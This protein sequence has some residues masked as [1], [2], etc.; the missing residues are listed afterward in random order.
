[1]VVHALSI[2]GI[3]KRSCKDELSIAL[4]LYTGLAACAGCRPQL[5]WDIRD[6]SEQSDCP[7]RSSPSSVTLHCKAAPSAAGT[8]GAADV[9]SLSTQDRSLSSSS[10][11]T[12]QMQGDG[13]SG[14]R[15]AETKKYC[16]R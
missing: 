14:S 10:M 2:W 12:K 13:C 3:P 9:S 5:V 15:S 8:S 1:M 11:E 4:S 16:C 7:A 6:V